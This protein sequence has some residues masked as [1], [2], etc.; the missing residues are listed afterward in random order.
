MPRHAKIKKMKMKTN[1]DS[2]DINSMF[3]EMLGLKD[4]D[5]G[6][7][8]PKL[9]EVRN[10][11]R[12]IH[13]ILTQF[14]GFVIFQKDFPSFTDHMEMI[15]K[16]TSEMQ[17]SLFKE[18]PLDK[19]ET[20]LDYY[21]K[22]KEEINKEFMELKES[23]Y[24]KT[25]IVLSSTLNKYKKSIGDKENLKD[26]FIGLEPGLSFRI[27]PFSSFD[28]KILWADKRAS[29]MVKNYVLNILN[30][31]LDNTFKLYKLVTSP[32]VNIEEFT[33]L[34]IKSLGELKKTPGLNRCHRA[35]KQ[36]ENSVD[37]LSNNFDGYYRDSVSSGN[38]N[39]IVE[40]FIIDVSTNSNGDANLTREFRLI[41][42]HMHKM[43]RDSGKSNDPNIQRVFSMLNKNF[44]LME[45]KNK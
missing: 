13:K 4:A 41:I 27:F 31:L 30:H 23:D 36:M 10:T 28:L 12:A 14:S 20:E 5:I 15:K 34:I 22:S 16:F 25:L 19:K 21:P 8:R 1:S 35:F 43:S 24:V 29:K 39:L 3:S 6:I 2:N 40:N 17:E 32:M 42:Q 26:N 9:V 7:V 33:K 44:D 37:M 45:G 18:F 11:L 38:P